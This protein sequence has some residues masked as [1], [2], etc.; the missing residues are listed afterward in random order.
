[1]LNVNVNINERMEALFIPYLFEFV[2]FAA[3]SQRIYVSDGIIFISLNIAISL[4]SKR[5]WRFLSSGVG[6][7]NPS[8]ARKLLMMSTGVRLYLR[9]R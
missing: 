5:I 8:C 3:G 1:M 7:D 9:A 4:S 6:L 2:I